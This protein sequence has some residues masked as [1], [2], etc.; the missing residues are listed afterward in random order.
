MESALK[1]LASFSDENLGRIAIFHHPT[2][3]DILIMLKEQTDSSRDGFALHLK[4]IEIRKQLVNQFIPALKSFD[5]QRIDNGGAISAYFEYSPL[6]LSHLTFLN[7]ESSIKLFY[8]LI[9]ASAFLQSKSMAHGDIRPE[10]VSFFPLQK[11]FKLCDKILNDS[12]PTIS[13]KKHIAAGS[14]LY[15]SPTYFN[16]LMN[17]RIDKKTIDYYKN[18][19]FAIGLVT[20]RMMYPRYFSILSFYNQAL[21]IFDKSE[22]FIAMQTLLV[23][24]HSERE[25]K[26]LSFLFQYVLNLPQRKRLRPSEALSKFEEF[27]PTLGIARLDDAVQLSIDKKLKSKLS[28]AQNLSQFKSYLDLE[29]TSA[30]HPL[31]P[32]SLQ[33]LSGEATPE[34]PPLPA[35]Q[36][37]GKQGPVQ[38]LPEEVQI[39]KP[40]PSPKIPVTQEKDDSKLKIYQPEPPRP[41][42][43]TVVA[44]P[45]TQ[46]YRPVTV[47]QPEVLNQPSFERKPAVPSKLPIRITD[48]VPTVNYYDFSTVRNV[49]DASKFGSTPYSTMSTPK[50]PIKVFDDNAVRP[51]IDVMLPTS[52]SSVKIEKTMPVDV[53]PSRIPSIRI[54]SELTSSKI[55]PQQSSVELNPSRPANY[56]PQ[57]ISL[58]PIASSYTDFKQTQVLPSSTVIQA[59]TWQDQYRQTDYR[60]EA[61]APYNIYDAALRPLAVST[62][63]KPPIQEFAEGARKVWAEPGTSSQKIATPTLNLYQPKE[64]FFR[65]S[66]QTTYTRIPVFSEYRQDTAPVRPQ[67]PPRLEVR[68]QSISNEEYEKLLISTHLAARVILDSQGRVPTIIKLENIER[69]PLSDGVQSIQRE[70]STPVQTGY[71]QKI[72]GRTAPAQKPTSLPVTTP[73]THF[74]SFVRPER[75]DLYP[76]KQTSSTALLS[77]MLSPGEIR[78]NENSNPNF[79]SLTAARRVTQVPLRKNGEDSSFEI[80]DQAN[81]VRVTKHYHAKPAAFA[82]A[83]DTTVK[84]STAK[85]NSKR[86]SINNRVR[87]RIDAPSSFYFSVPKDK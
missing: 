84:P 62:I 2:E 49:P 30:G 67:Q 53:N 55:H 75:T 72:E 6:Q 61:S 50:Q 29:A 77:K 57:R 15:L 74:A 34:Q 33:N 66:T 45:G 12:N 20:L 16:E 78:I 81:G 82:R 22:F 52:F 37:P 17:N 11:A 69:R 21:R 58:P 14:N 28:F 38:P 68:R 71:F 8:D 40:S 36:D 60:N 10:L 70:S 39:P 76:Q 31:V 48:S 32:H 5:V 87:Y 44:A 64:S 24:S 19:T 51:N 79:P 85:F 3:P 18:E 35:P 65:G 43:Q 13:Q 25:S 59:S 26:F 63:I 27:L 46:V 42:V 7:I 86:E 73:R 9:R 4:Q 41:P 47:A 56:R 83:P 23:H 80:Y 1:Q 54:P